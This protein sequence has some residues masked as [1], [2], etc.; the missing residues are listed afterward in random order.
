MKTFKI[1]ATFLL[2]IMAF[3]F[4]SAMINFKDELFIDEFGYALVSKIFIRDELTTLIKYLTNLGSGKTMFLIALGILLVNRD[5]SIGVCASANLLIVNNFNFWFKQF[6]ARPR[7]I[8]NRIIDE[9]GYSFPSGHAMTSIVFYGFL[10][11]LIYKYCQNEKLKH[12]LIIG[13]VLLIFLIGLSRVYLGVHYTSD[14]L[15]GFLLG[16]AILVIFINFLEKYRLLS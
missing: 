1:K 9:M 8:D 15:A 6:F 13:L 5:K 11:Y 10:I 2:T 16:Y 4:L 14:V 7:P 12:Y 3:I